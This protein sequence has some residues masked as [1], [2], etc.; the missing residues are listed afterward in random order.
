MFYRN[1]RQDFYVIDS[2]LQLCSLQERR[3][4]SPHTPSLCRS[5][6]LLCFSIWEIRRMEVA[7]CHTLTQSTDLSLSISLSLHAENLI[8]L[9][10]AHYLHRNHITAACRVM[11][12]HS[13]T[14]K[15]KARQADREDER[16]VNAWFS[17]SLRRKA[18]KTSNKRNMKA[19]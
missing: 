6:R 14:E 8:H 17:S 15:Q 12:Q 1:W 18:E 2:D 9:C 19:G 13:L 11:N 5:D 10:F 4:P 7:H 16:Q 3:H